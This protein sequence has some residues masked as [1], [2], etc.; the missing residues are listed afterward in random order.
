MDVFFHNWQQKCHTPA[1]AVEPV[2]R[3]HET[4]L[5]SVLSH[6]LCVSLRNIPGIIARVPQV[7]TVARTTSLYGAIAARGR[8][9]ARERHLIAPA[10]TMLPRP[11]AL[12]VGKNAACRALPALDLCRGDGLRL[13][14]GFVS[15][16]TAA[17][18]ERAEQ[19]GL[20]PA[21]GPWKA[22]SSRLLQEGHR[23]NV[24]SDAKATTNPIKAKISGTLL[25]A[26]VREGGREAEC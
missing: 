15:R 3:L 22:G 24:V 11:W 12:R 20:M 23:R 14:R 18:E 13:E 25:E 2:A 16:R 5:P 17:W 9:G 21:P 4:M 6:P 26:K 7:A 1:A 8:H 10:S 19:G